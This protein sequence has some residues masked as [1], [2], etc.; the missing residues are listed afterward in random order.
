MSEAAWTDD[1]FDTFRAHFDAD[2]FHR[3]LDI[4]VEERRPGYGRIRLD[5]GP[6]TP[7]GIGGGGRATAARSFS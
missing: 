6:D 5:K 2:P 3:M 1:D 7:A 4:H